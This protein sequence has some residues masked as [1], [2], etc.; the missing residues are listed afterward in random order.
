MRRQIIAGAT[1]L[2]LAAG[3][4]LGFA[5]AAAAH[6]G[7]VTGT[8]QC[9]EDGTVTVRWTYDARSVPDGVEA[10]TKAM[11]TSVG[12]L[13]PIDGVEK[14]GQIFLSVW[15]EHQINVPGA[16]VRTGN[17]A[18]AF[19]TVGIPGDYAGKVTTMVQ[20]DWRG[21]PSEDPVGEVTVPGDCEPPVVVPPKPDDAVTFSEWI[22]APWECGDE[23]TT[24]TR[25]KTVT[26]WKLEQ[27]VWVPGASVTTTETRERELTEAE[28]LLYQGDDPDGECF[29]EVPSPE[30]STW[31]EFEVGC[32]SVVGDVVTA[33]EYTRIVSHDLDP[34]TG[35][36]Y[37]RDETTSRDVDYTI[38]AAD[39]G[40]VEECEPP[41]EEPPVTEPKPEPTTPVVDVTPETPAATPAPRDT[42]SAERLAQTGASGLDLGAPIGIAAFLLVVG[43]ALV[44]G[45]R[46]AHRR[47]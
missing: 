26:T 39:L 3:G 30:T 27:N 6:T 18:A 23:R 15:A 12:T 16:P 24:E 44:T 37:A 45:Q 10:E 36:V 29:V 4:V 31:L 42:P 46:M 17:W 13:A 8:A 38:T 5:G 40:S 11:T 22:A 21:G 32:E 41:V 14:G 33:T 7:A 19:A 35:E 9:Q 28:R 43:A 34:V 1:A 47:R 25:E 2:L 20:T